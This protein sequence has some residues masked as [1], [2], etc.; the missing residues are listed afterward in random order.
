M[1]VFQDKVRL[2]APPELKYVGKSEEK[3]AVAELRVRVPNIK[4]DSD[5]NFKERGF[6]ANVS[7]WGKCAEQLVK[8]VTTGDQIYLIGNLYQDKWKDKETGDEKTGIKIDCRLAFPWLP[9]LESLKY[10]P[11]KAK[12]GGGHQDADSEDDESLI[13]F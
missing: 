10:K 11:R 8:L 3:S 7:V 4:R 9:D 5:G 12:D 1:S 2:A 6:W 13:P